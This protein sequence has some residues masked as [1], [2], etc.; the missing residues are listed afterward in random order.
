[1]QS[2]TWDPEQTAIALGLSYIG[3][4]DELSVFDRALSAEEIAMLHDLPK[5][6]TSLLR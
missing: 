2:F 6:V 4:L 5:G 3:A 1:V